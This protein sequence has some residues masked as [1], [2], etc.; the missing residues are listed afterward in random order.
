MAR[1]WTPKPA[2][3]S[4]TRSSPT[5][6]NFFLLL[7]N[8]LNTK[9]PFLP[10]LYKLWKTRLK[11]LGFLWFLEEHEGE[12]QVRGMVWPDAWESGYIVA[13]FAMTPVLFVDVWPTRFID[14]IDFCRFSTHLQTETYYYP[15]CA[16]KSV[17]AQSVCLSVVILNM[18]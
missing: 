3:M 1:H 8:S 18:K 7:L 2:I 17:S 9:L 11:P 10:T 12:I 14:F 15:E 16:L 5:G 13:I 6:G 4:C